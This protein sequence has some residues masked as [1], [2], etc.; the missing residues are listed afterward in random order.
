MAKLERLFV[1]SIYRAALLAGAGG[2]QL[3]R[4]LEASAEAIAAEDRA[5]QAWCRKHAYKGYTSYASLQDLPWRDPVV[6]DLV[7]RLDT[8]VARFAETL[9]YDLDGG[10]LTL[11]SLWINILEPGGRHTGHIHPNSAVSGT[12]YVSLPKGSAGIR[13]EDPRLPQMMAAPRRKSEAQDA[14]RLFFDIA[15][16]PGTVLLWESY[17]RH[18]VPET[19]GRERR[20]SISFN[21]RLP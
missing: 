18:E 6:A 19:R 5:G 11:D 3:R 16:E 2:E 21:Y 14:N 17:V 4:E 9:E 1:T 8:H 13:F 10:A 15:P 7:K 20:I 12:Y